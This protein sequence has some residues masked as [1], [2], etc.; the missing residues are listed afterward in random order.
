M[1]WLCETKILCYKDI[2]NF[3]V[4]L[5]GEDIYSD[6][7]KNVETRFDTSDY[8]LDIQLPK[9]ENKKVVGL[10]KDQLGG[11]IMS[12]FV[13]LRPKMYSYLT[14]NKDKD[15]KSKRHKTVCHKEK[16]LNLVITNIV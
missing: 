14:D 13:A 12:E 10:M 11:I 2:D 7:G 5:K 9:W 4:Y 1:V 8:E 3:I 6:T 15:K 16:T